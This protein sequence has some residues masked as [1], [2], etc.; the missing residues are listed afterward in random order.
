MALVVPL[1]AAP[2]RPIGTALLR[3][4]LRRS[5]F[6]LLQGWSASSATRESVLVQKDGA[7]VVFLIPPR[8]SGEHSFRLRRPLSA[9]TVEAM[10][11]AGRTG[12]L[13]GLDYRGRA[14]LAAGRRIPGSPWS[15]VCKVDGEES[16][17]PAEQRM[18]WLMAVLGLMMLTGG[19]LTWG[20]WRKVGTK[21]L[22]E[23]YE[24]QLRQKALEG[25]HEYLVRHAFDIILLTDQEGCIL[26][27]N[28]TA[29]S[30][31]GR[32]REE[33]FELR[34]FDLCAP[35]TREHC[36]A[37]FSQLRVDQANRGETVHW[38]ADGSRFPVE[39]SAR[40]ISIDS[41]GFV[42][43][44]VRDLTE[45]KQAEAA[46][47]ESEERYR[48]I[49]ETAE[50]GIWEIDDEERV[51]FVNRKMAEM[52]GYTRQEMIGKPLYS[53]MQ[54]SEHQAARES[55][56]RRRQGLREQFLARYRRRD[57]TDLW[58]IAKGSPLFDRNG[59][60][61][62]AFAMMTDVTSRKG[63]EDEIRRV[64]SQLRR[65]SLRLLH[66]Q[67]EERRRIA[68]ELHD[69]TAQALAALAMNLDR[70]QRTGVN[71]PQ[72]RML[73]SDSRELAQRCSQEVRDLSHLLH[74]PLL[75]ELGLPTV[76]RSYAEG[77]TRRTGIRVKL[78]VPPA[79]GRLRPEI[80]TSVFRIVQEALSNVQRHSGS[81]TAFLRV[82][83]GPEQLHLE[84]AD[85]GT[86]FPS[87]TLEGPRAPGSR[88]GLG[89][90]SMTE[91]V[92]E[93]GG[94]LEVLTSSAGT[95]IRVKMPLS[96]ERVEDAGNEDSRGG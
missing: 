73:L 10:V 91:R 39:V 11:A 14:V 5:L 89:L 28:E 53:F 38:R 32:K 83:V 43:V 30:T 36:V 71:S 45:L 56:A 64:N 95:K 44:I 33:L 93:L 42:H 87:A 35:E 63:A 85:E 81:A 48:E 90:L 23:V 19:C 20:A 54:E 4:D 62:G 52:L 50:E 78:D 86:G 9:Q 47:R 49:V 18:R 80:E 6:P 94:E 2:T 13:K 92:Q 41:E 68:R 8:F 34:I 84:V 65:L 69:S 82:Q 70:I 25:H 16:H 7:E 66:S 29:F 3:L 88:F 46:L 55:V 37:I 24:V 12:S 17:G 77:F 1:A 58:A 22:R 21:H 79:L 76:L 40:L 31:Y 61:R 26:D 15:L 74:P 75:E 59:R 67:D 51:V 60:Y 96:A 57:G 27:A 72:F